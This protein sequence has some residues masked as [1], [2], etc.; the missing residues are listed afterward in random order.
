MSEVEGIDCSISV[1]IAE[2]SFCCEE[3]G[4]SDEAI[5]SYQD[6]GKNSGVTRIKEEEKMRCAASPH[7]RTIQFQAELAE[8]LNS[9]PFLKAH[10][11]PQCYFDCFI[12]IPAIVKLIAPYEIEIAKLYADKLGYY[13]GNEWTEAQIEIS[14]H[15]N[16]REA[17]N[18]LDETKK[19]DYY[20]PEFQEN[21]L[22]K[23]CHEEYRRGLPEA[24]NTLKTLKDSILLPFDSDEFMDLNHFA[25]FAQFVHL[26]LDYQLEDVNEI[27]KKAHQE[28]SKVQE[29]LPSQYRLGKLLEIEARSKNPL[30]L[31]TLET[32]RKS[33]ST[34]RNYNLEVNQY[35]P[36]EASTDYIQ[37]W[38]NI[39]SIEAKYPFLSSQCE[40]DLKFLLSIDKMLKN[41]FPDAEW[42]FYLRSLI[43]VF[44][45]NDWNKALLVIDVLNSEFSRTMA[46]LDL[47]KSEGIKEEI[48]IRRA[49][50]EENL[51]CRISYLVAAFYSL[52]KSGQINEALPYLEQAKSILPK[53]NNDFKQFHFC[54]ILQ[55]EISFHLPSAKETLSQLYELLKNVDVFYSTTVTLI[56]AELVLMID[57]WCGS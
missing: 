33:T 50:A 2:S 34:V 55:A 49:E 44:A 43:K 38:V 8:K 31:E 5:T 25:H 51:A 41:E 17:Q 35:T 15:M 54:T 45:L 13:S 28:V 52:A 42:D 46:I 53:L 30:A 20:H 26:L 9:P 11:L 16:L 29:K 3:S 10:S 39:V 4:H 24:E 1:T 7:L 48:F 36:E 19:A 37:D 18:L 27:I 40:E 32:L 47:I 23:I 12:I 21:Y 22:I 57:K 14:K 56:E 6:P